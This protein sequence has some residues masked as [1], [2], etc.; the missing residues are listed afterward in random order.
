M[1]PFVYSFVVVAACVMGSDCQAQ[2]LFGSG[3]ALNTT[4]TS[5]GGNPFAL[6]TPTGRTGSTGPSFGGTG[7]TGGTANRSSASRS[8][9]QGAQGAQGA[10]NTADGSLGA[11]IGTSGFVGRGDNA[12]RFIGSQ[13]TTTNARRGNTANQ[14]SLFQNLLGGNDFNQDRNAANTPAQNIIPQ[15][16]L[17]FEAETVVTP[18]LP[19]AIQESL[20]KLPALGARANGVIAHADN[21]G[22]VTLSGHVRSENDRKLIETLVRMEPGVRGVRNELAIA[23]AP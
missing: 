9:S 5:N 17:G 18:Q 15:M 3:G 22:V 1:K 19:V 20:M 23:S 10:L 2:S 11:T 14:F 16:K 4:A 12:N 8:G 13:N 6:A 7:A 21:A